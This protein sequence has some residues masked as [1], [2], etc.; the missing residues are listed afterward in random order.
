MFCV[1]TLSKTYEMSASDTRQRQEWTTGKERNT[2][3]E[4][5]FHTAGYHHLGNFSYFLIPGIP[6]YNSEASASLCLLSQ[7]ASLSVFFNLFVFVSLSLLSS[8]RIAD[9][10]HP[11]MTFPL[12]F[13]SLFLPLTASSF[14]YFFEDNVAVFSL[15]NDKVR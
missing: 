8:L 7:Y 4:H 12:I 3:T 11:S 13:P 1:K 14:L 9:A 10:V 5:C 6:F 15:Y 2:F